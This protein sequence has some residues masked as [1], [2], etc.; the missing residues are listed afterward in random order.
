MVMQVESDSLIRAVV[1]RP[2]I[3]MAIGNFRELASECIIRHDSDPV[4]GRLLAEGLCSAALMS[5]LL[6]GKEKYSI[7]INYPGPAR[8]LLIDANA[9][10]R[11]RGLI[12]NPH[13]MEFADSVE[14]ACGDGA[15]VA[16][17]RSCEG[18]ILNS[19]EIKTAFIMPSGALG[20]FMSTSDQVES[21]IHC[22][23][24]F[25]PNPKA[26][27]GSAVAVLIQ[28]MPGCDAEEFDQIRSRLL[29]AEAGRILRDESQQLSEKL[30]A[31][32]QWLLPSNEVPNYKTFFA[33]TPQ[34]YCTCSPERMRD[35]AIK[36]LG[37]EE[38][39]KL[40][41]ENP[42]PAVRCEFCNRE[43]RLSAEDLQ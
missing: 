31:L 34:F 12:R 14:V 38:L 22:E 5:V 32:L 35:I 4:S 13:V 41:Q 29:E 3:R 27:V 2:A 9:D 42:H 15:M 40:L 6:E 11:I 37:R 1:E 10:G 28:A 25:Q 30:Q 39:Q 17:T 21:E 33:V 7:R 20:F 23:L 18:K 36:T 43:Y 26:P 19:G 16:V 24:R 8:G